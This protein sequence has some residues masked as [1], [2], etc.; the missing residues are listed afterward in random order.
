MSHI[1]PP[2]AGATGA[3]AQ[4]SAS[5]AF[6]PMHGVEKNAK[7]LVLWRAAPAAGASIAAS[8][9]DTSVAGAIGAGQP[10]ESLREAA[11]LGES[12]QRSQWVSLLEALQGTTDIIRVLPEAPIA[13]EL[14]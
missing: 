12:R 13:A 5:A 6:T 10:I 8:P 4:M 3:R 11:G 9:P 7:L 14:A 2:S 1:H